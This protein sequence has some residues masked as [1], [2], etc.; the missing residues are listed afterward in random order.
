MS[1]CIYGLFSCKTCKEPFKLEF[2]WEFTGSYIPFQQ[3]ELLFVLQISRINL[4]QRIFFPNILTR[5]KQRNFP[6]NL[7]NIQERKEGVGIGDG[8]W[9]VNKTVLTATPLPSSLLACPGWGLWLGRF[10]KVA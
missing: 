3:P 8:E 1:V 2:L 10:G 5:R 9:E 6:L 7:I 4:G